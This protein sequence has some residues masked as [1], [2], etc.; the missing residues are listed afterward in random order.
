MLL[1]GG[2]G[3]LYLTLFQQGGHIM[4]TPF[5]FA[6]LDLKTNSISGSFS[7]TS[8]WQNIVRILIA[9][10]SIR[11]AAIIERSFKKNQQFFDFLFFK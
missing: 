7:L 11:K 3:G 4:P 1:A 10:G 6:H 8:I 2:Q 5:L 9:C